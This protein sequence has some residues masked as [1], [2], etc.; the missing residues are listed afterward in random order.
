MTEKKDLEKQKS[1][2]AQLAQQ[3]ERVLRPPVDICEDSSGI[4]LH[5]DMPGVPK[6]GFNIQVNKDSLS[7]EGIASIEMPENME[8]LYA[9]IITMKYQRNFSLSSE[10]DATRIDA[11]LK[12]GVLSLHIP[13]RE[14]LQPRKIEVRAG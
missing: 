6:D 3:D 13:K 9:D 14:E 2:A 1:K 8:A 11:S 12:D 5:A 10:L 7:I 4:I